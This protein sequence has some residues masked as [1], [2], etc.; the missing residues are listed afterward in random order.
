MKMGR[1]SQFVL[2]AC[3]A[4][5]P[6]MANGGSRPPQT[7]APFFSLAG[8][9]YNTPQQLVLTDTT[10]GAVIYYTT[11]GQTPNA[12]S[13]IY[14]TPIVISSTKMVAAIAIAPGYSWSVESAKSYTYVPFPIAPAPYFSLAG[15]TYNTP[16]KLVLT[17]SAP[18]AK[19]CYTTNG[20]TPVDDNG[21]EVGDCIPYTGPITVAKSELVKAAAKAPGYNVSN[22]S[23]KKYTYAP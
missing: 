7:S 21:F 14:S 16:Q 18:G 20:E 1:R 8:G 13:A 23:S 15:G 6:L 2:I 19:I 22:V 11:N 17:D 9:L 4:F 12:S 5:V 3:L 10:P